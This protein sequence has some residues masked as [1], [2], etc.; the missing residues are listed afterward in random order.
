[1]THEQPV[2]PLVITEPT[3]RAG[4][5]L[6]KLHATAEEATRILHANQQ[7]QRDSHLA[8]GVARGALAAELDRGAQAGEQNT[9]L[10]V[11]LVRKIEDAKIAANPS[12]HAPRIAAATERQNQAAFA[13]RTHIDLNIAALLSEIRPEAERITAELAAASEK[14]TPYG[15]AYAEVRAKVE[16]LTACV[17]R[18]RTAQAQST[19]W[20]AQPLAPLN[21]RERWV[22]PEGDGQVPM[23]ASE[24]IEAYDRQVHPEPAPVVT[25][26]E[27]AA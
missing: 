21:C 18:G 26:D 27:P 4:R 22:L 17:H 7:A 2:P 19:P 14:L 15:E 10:E 1:M 6:V 8:I 16:E 9:D 11:A 24:V 23:P 13:V 20:H 3:T 5:E 25:A 12:L